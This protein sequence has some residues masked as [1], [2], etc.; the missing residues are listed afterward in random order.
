MLS[1]AFVLPSAAQTT[2]D[3]VLYHLIILC[4]LF[5]V[6]SFG[7]PNPLDFVRRMPDSNPD[8]IFV[9][10]A[11]FAPEQDSFRFLSEMK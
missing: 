8:K 11:Y 1:L 4:W 7:D 2:I 6:R 10:D 9:S 3:R 5:T